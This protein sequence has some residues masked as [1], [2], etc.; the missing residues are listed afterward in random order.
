MPKDTYLN[1]YSLIIKRLQR[2]AATYEQIVKYLENESEIK[3]K[4]YSISK[5]TLQ[6]D[7]KDIFFLNLI[8]K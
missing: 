7:I 5:R 4:N 8:L 6:R 3:G 1:R 2:G